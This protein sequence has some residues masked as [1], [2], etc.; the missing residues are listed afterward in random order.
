MSPPQL[1]LGDLVSSHGATQGFILISATTSFPSCSFSVP[2]ARA[3][4][5][6]PKH[7]VPPWPSSPDLI[8]ALQVIALHKRPTKGGERAPAHT[9]VHSIRQARA[10]QTVTAR[11]P[12]PQHREMAELA[13][14]IRCVCVRAC[15]WASLSLRACSCALSIRQLN[16]CPTSH[17]AIPRTRTAHIRR[18]RV[19]WGARAAA[20]ARHR[21]T[22]T[23]PEQEST[24][25]SGASAGGHTRS[26]SDPISSITGRRERAPPR[27]RAQS[28]VNT[29]R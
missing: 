9:H 15:V 14:V 13:A 22:L 8:V 7:A 24:A 20:W 17:S 25:A 10:H 19:R 27:T 1:V 2:R 3:H 21:V 29:A 28:S 23:N 4:T 5:H 11:L 26:S 16:I 18:A 6:T 12:S